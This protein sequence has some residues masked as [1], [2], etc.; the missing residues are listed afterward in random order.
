M[1]N[2]NVMI[3][4]LRYLKLSGFIESIVEQ[5]TSKRYRELPFEDR[6]LLLIDKECLRREN[7][8]LTTRLRSAHIPQSGAS[9]DAIDLK[10]ERGIC[11]TELL[12]LGTCQWIK[13]RLSMIITGPTGV[14]KSFISCAL[15]DQA[16]RL[17][18]SVLYARTSDLIAELL[19]AKSDGS[20]KALQKRF[21]KVDLLIIDDF[22][23]DTLETVHLREFLDL[24]DS[25]FRK[26]SSLFVS[27][28]PVKDWH[29]NIA[30]STIAD[31]LLDRIVHDALRLE[32]Q[33]DSMRKLT[34]PISRKANTS[35]R[36]GKT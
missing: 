21:S 2:E 12:E 36:S 14:G 20:F 30:D 15:A 33:G 1:M 26:T 8:R 5:R 11:K 4:K 17:G 28:L 34:S 18:L 29:K 25:R 3:D 10:I 6:L 22:L 24:I 7:Q 16:C 19:L 35:L 27:Q 23:R 32:L 13:D 31:A 9:L